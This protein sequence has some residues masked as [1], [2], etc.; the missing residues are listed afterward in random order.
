MCTYLP[1]FGSRMYSIRFSVR[2]NEESVGA[3]TNAKPRK[4]P[5]D[6]VRDGDW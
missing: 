3:E 4:K 1:F 5:P 2:R 6:Q